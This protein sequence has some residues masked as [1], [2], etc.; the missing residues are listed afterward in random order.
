MA[1]ANVRSIP[2]VK[3]P[4][5]LARLKDWEKWRRVYAGGDDFIQ[6]YLK[7][8]ST[9]E[10]TSDFN[11][12]RAITPNAT[13][14]KAAVND[15]KN[16]IFQRM[17]D[18]TRDGGSKTYQESVRGLEN[19]VDLRGSTMN[20][21]VGQDLLPELLVMSR[22][23]VYVDMP[24]L[25]PGASLLETQGVRPYLYMYRV[26]D[27]LSWSCRDVHDPDTYQSVLLRDRCLDYDPNTYLA[28]G[29]I[30]RY[31]LLWVNPV[32]GKVNVQF[33]DENGDAIG[34]DGT[35][36]VGAVELELTTIPFV[37]F[38]IKQ[39]LIEDVCNHQIAMLNLGSVDVAYAL[40]ANFPFYIEQ[41]DLRGGSSHL[42]ENN[43]PDSAAVAGSQ[44]GRDEEITV[45]P[46]QGRKYDLKAE[47]PAFINPSSEPLKASI[48]LQEKLKEDIRLLV[49]L[50][51]TNINPKMA[52]AESKQLDQTSLESGLSYIGLV[53][54]SGERR[55][56]R[57]WATYEKAKAAT[58]KYPERYSIKSAEERRK[59]AKDHA[60]LKFKVPST[61]FQKQIDKDIIDILLGSKVSVELLETMKRE[62]DASTYR[63][64]DPD[65]ITADITNGLVSNATASKARGYADGESDQ[66]EKD[67][68]SKMEKLAKAQAPPGE[69]PGN[70]A[71][72]GIGA[73]KV[74]G[75]T[76]DEKAGKPQRGD[77]AA[78]SKGSDTNA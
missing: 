4:E 67:A 56:A 17:T 73:A 29:E 52:S 15:V 68:V 51:V 58:I 55:I 24:E 76:V 35:K 60:D 5:Y 40:K 41:H 30:E 34:K 20:S 43:N 27:I 75:A 48:E 21:F 53:L 14:A 46:V 45:G 38:D 44:Q 10:K 32:T 28:L 64:S 61:T 2:D 71:A 59:E 13:F 47:A 65:I 26:E 1:A 74:P 50:A 54:E 63:T 9:R 18:I 70:P 23:G 78:I 16:S 31:R 12:R 36:G 8:V 62:A 42:L 25:L 11:L 39:S 3:H 77:G 7:K 22:V 33:Y 6:F 19:G 37:M 66:A 57:L 49:N 72:R 69:M